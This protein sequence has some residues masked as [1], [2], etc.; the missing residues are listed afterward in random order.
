M[1]YKLD[2]WLQEVDEISA[3]VQHLFAGVADEMLNRQPAPGRWS[4]AQNLHHLVIFNESYFPILRQV[5]GGTY[6]P[7]FA[8][9]LPLLPKYLGQ[10]L[11][12][13]VQPDARRRMKTFPRWEPQGPEFHRDAMSRFLSHQDL[14]KQIMRESAD[15][16]NRGTIIESPLSRAIVYP[17]ATA[18]EI[19][20][21]HEKRH[22]RQAEDALKSL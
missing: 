6:V 21:A 17:L 3:A 4:V 15:T 22:I 14:L 19:I 18:F 11:L 9:K 1:S 16:I 8:A 7:P 13:G 20:V 10:T 2:A 12:R 5:N